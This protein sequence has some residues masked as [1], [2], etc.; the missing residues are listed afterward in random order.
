[1]CVATGAILAQFV[2]EK[3]TLTEEFAN[4]YN[5]FQKWLYLYV[6]LKLVM[7]T[8]LV[9]WTLMECGPI[10]SGLSFN[11]YDKETGK[12]KFDRV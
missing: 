10:A 4:E 8:Y 3:F 1:M 11:G 5:L 6:A 2:D 12:P 7:Q 9:G